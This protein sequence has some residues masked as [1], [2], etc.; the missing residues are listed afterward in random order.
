MGHYRAAYGEHYLT[1]MRSR[2]GTVVFTCQEGL[3]G[4]EVLLADLHSHELLLITLWC[5]GAHLGHD[6]DWVK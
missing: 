1:S 4:M 2:L 5:D 6:V 3:Y